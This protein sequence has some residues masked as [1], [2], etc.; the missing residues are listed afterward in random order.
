MKQSLSIYNKLCQHDIIA[1]SIT[2]IFSHDT[3]IIEITTIFICNDK[4][5]F[6]FWICAGKDPLMKNIRQAQGS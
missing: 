3:N 5:F 6:Y 2:Y 1:V 4:D